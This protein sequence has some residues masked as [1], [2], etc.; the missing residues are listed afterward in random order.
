MKLE[1]KQWTEMARGRS[2]AWKHMGLLGRFL[3]CYSNAPFFF[4]FFEKTVYIKFKK[5]NI[6]R[7]CKSKRAQQG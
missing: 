6:E 3:T 2:R 1:T 4:F 5:L 7:M